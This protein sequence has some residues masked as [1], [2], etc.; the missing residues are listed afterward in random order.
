MGSYSPVDRNA[1]SGKES[2]PLIKLKASKKFFPFLVW[3][4]LLTRRTVRSD[5]LAGLTGA[6]VVLPQG[7]A[8]AAIAGMPPQYG[9]YAAMIPAIIGALF[10]SSNHLV[11]GPTTAASIVLFSALSELAVPGSAEYISYALI[12][13][14]MVGVLEL[15]MGLARLG[16]LTNFIS[17]SVIVGFTAGAAILIATNQLKHFFGMD[18]PEGLQ[19]HETLLYF[20][21][22]KRGVHPFAVAT[23]GATLLSGILVKRFFRRL[24]YMVV[25]MLVGGVVAIALNWYLGYMGQGPLISVLGTVPGTLPP[26]S[27]P[28]ISLAAIK[29]LAP[30][31]LA[32][33]LFAL[34]EA[35]S[36]SRSI[37][38]RSGQYIDGNQEFIGQ[39]LSNIVGSFFSAY[40]ATGSFNRSGVNYEVGAKTP[41]AAMFA[42]GLLI[43]IVIVVA[44]LLAYL[45][46]AA[47]AAILFLVA[48]GIIDFKRIWTIVRASRS[49]ALVLWVTFF[50]TILLQL[51]FAILLGVFLSM[52][53][54]LRQTSQPRVMVRMPD[55]GPP[56]HFTT[57]PGLWE[58][59]QIKLVRIDGSIY[60]G[61]VSYVAERLRIIA[62]RNPE[63][64]HLVIF[65]RSINF[66]DV[67]GAELLA[68]EAR[69]RSQM[70]G[71]LYFHQVKDTAH[72]IL[73]KGGYLDDIG[74]ENLFQTKGMAIHH[75]FEKLDRNICANCTK[76]V[77]EECAGLPRVEDLELPLGKG[78][79]KKIARKKSTPKKRRPAKKKAE[80]K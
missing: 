30:V 38:A 75:A 63:Q 71:G 40:V 78:A 1:G 50:A 11:S 12:L 43:V 80:A 21:D 13:T 23:A 68:R 20:W 36:I 34:T 76:R 25:A 72:A 51:E 45:P 19:L 56:R 49:E 16:V 74:E 9:L 44:P 4:P 53:V 61:A 60:F 77:F 22:H 66:V 33:S 14:L 42:G 3:W 55:P 41:L 62:K 37:A 24:P 2:A 32:V 48:W 27:T 65:A 59:P 17:H 70:G 73:A 5:F 67:A 28:D 57:D 47:M 26:L 35:V 54:F 39:G 64:K 29:Q 6:V 46:N 31:A 10:G 7:V 15:A 58:C 79:K 52:I 18:I 8:F 69:Q